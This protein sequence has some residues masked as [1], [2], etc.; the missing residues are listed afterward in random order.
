MAAGEMNALHVEDRA[1]KS[2]LTKAINAHLVSGAERVRHAPL[3]RAQLL[4]ASA[5]THSRTSAT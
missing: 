5:P 4:S 3:A 1:S 2:P